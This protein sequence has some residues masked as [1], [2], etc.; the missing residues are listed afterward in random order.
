MNKTRKITDNDL[1]KMISALD[2]MLIFLTQS[3]CP[4]NPEKCKEEDKLTTIQ[5]PSC[6]HIVVLGLPH[7]DFKGV[8]P[9]PESELERLAMEDKNE[10]PNN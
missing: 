1:D 8:T 7:P 5:C 2:S 6:G 10:K 9:I 3:I 4:F